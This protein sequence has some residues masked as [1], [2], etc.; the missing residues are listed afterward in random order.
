MARP[1]TRTYSPLFHVIER[2]AK[3]RGLDIQAVADSSGLN[4]GT[5]Y[6]IRDPRVSKLNRIADALGV[7]VGRLAAMATKTESMNA[8][9]R[10]AR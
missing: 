6:Q 7:P 5:I 3:R 8:G 1:R 10:V 2:I 9:R 4:V